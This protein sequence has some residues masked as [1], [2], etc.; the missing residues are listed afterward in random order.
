M[1]IRNR[2][3][4]GAFWVAVYLLLILSPLFL[5]LIGPVPAGRN[6]GSSSRSRWA[7]SPFRSWGFSS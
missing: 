5:L 4:Q 2:T 3:A 7:S 1:P 6:F